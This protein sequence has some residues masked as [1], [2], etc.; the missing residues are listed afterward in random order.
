MDTDELS[1]EAYDGVI[2]EAEKLHHDLTLQFGVLASTC[3]NEEEYLLKAKLL[4]EEIQKL[5][6][7]SLSE[8]FFDSIPDKK[9]L[10]FTLE[11]MLNNILEVETI[12]GN[13]RHYDF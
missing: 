2:V 1:N 10:N 13:K 5:D 11:K 7:S 6:K 12:P 3:N 9:K 8:I 4:I